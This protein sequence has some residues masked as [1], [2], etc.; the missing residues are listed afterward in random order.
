MTN[1]QSYHY[2]KGQI[3]DNPDPQTLLLSNNTSYPGFSSDA[4]P[5]N[6]TIGVNTAGSTAK[7]SATQTG[8]AQLRY[9]AGNGP[10]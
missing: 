10:S 1:A 4:D 3:V 9:S 7:Y 5:R 6:L 8:A 2:D